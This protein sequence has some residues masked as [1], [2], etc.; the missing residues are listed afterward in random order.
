MKRRQFFLNSVLGIPSLSFGSFILKNDTLSSLPASKTEKVK[1][2]LLTMQ[3]AAWEQGVA[4]QAFLESGDEDITILMARESVLR[5]NSEGQLSVLYTENGVTDPAA[6]G[7]AVLFAWKK[8]GDERF[9]SAADRMLEY[10]M[11]KAPRTGGIIH[12]V[13]DKPE[14]WID[15]MYM[16]P[17][18]LAIAGEYEEALKQI[19]GWKSCLW[20]ESD[21]LF[22]H[23]YDL[24]RKKFV[25]KAYW[26]VGNGWAASGMARVIDIL[27][28]N[29][30]KEK[31]ALIQTEN[32]LIGACM[33]YLRP[34]GYFHD[35]IDDP[36]SFVETNLSQMLAYTI[37]RGVSSGWL[38]GHLLEK[39]RFMQQAAERKVDDLGLV[40]GVCGAPFFN[41]AGTAPEGQSFFILME[42][43]ADKFTGH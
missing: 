6:A 33:E 39:A 5:Q 2:A 23:I 31:E 13:K 37:F 4:A 9:K 7:E 43:V 26:G 11:I 14:V 19:A 3:R 8:T 32:E 1:R 24:E 38:P 21:H 30:R 28:E 12:H 22:S 34:D 18:F 10:L 16:A 41:S 15:S 35:V 27:P 40:Q 25:R 42:S 20:S 36:K 17:P 29:F